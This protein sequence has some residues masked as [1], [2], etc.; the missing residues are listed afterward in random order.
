MHDDNR[1]RGAKAFRSARS[2]K[3][4]VS[5]WTV[6][7]SIFHLT[8][9][10]HQIFCTN[11]YIA[12]DVY[13]GRTERLNLNPRLT[14]KYLEGKSFEAHLQAEIV[15]NLGRRA[16]ELSEILTDGNSIQW[17][18]NEVSCGVGMQ[19][20]DLMLAFIN[21]GIRYVSPVELKSVQ[22]Q[23]AHIRQIQR[24]V[25]WVQQY[26]IPNL[27]SV[28]SPTLITLKSQGSLP[29]AVREEIQRFNQHN[30]GS[31]CERLR[32]LEFEVRSAGLSFSVRDY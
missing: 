30:S 22:L 14:Q 6:K 32:L 1:V 19:R 31:T 9:Y 20:I 24:Y 28:I 11:E 13:A 8:K 23:A 25:D 29:Y 18:G 15:R 16:D 10:T 3:C 26:Y 4:L 12:R 17:I 7:A 21:D 2:Q 5:L 27:P